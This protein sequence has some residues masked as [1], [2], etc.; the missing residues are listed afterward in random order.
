MICK[1]L[2]F[3]QTDV[4]KSDHWSVVLNVIVYD[5]RLGDT[6]YN[7]VSNTFVCYLSVLVTLPAC[8][9]VQFTLG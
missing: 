9:H 7:V 2:S 1:M 3:Y 4:D 8:I 5:N 6:Q